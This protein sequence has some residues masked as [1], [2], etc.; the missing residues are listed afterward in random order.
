MKKGGGLMRVNME[1]DP[2]GKWRATLNHTCLVVETVIRES[3]V[4]MQLS[5]DGEVMWV[6]RCV[7]AVED[8]LVL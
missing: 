4:H 7:Q 3:H 2:G 5:R 1:K 6:R 8:I